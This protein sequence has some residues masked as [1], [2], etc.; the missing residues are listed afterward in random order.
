MSQ[1]PFAPSISD[2]AFFDDTLSLAEFSCDA[3]A[4]RDRPAISTV[5]DF[6]NETKS[7]LPAVSQ[8]LLA[9]SA[10]AA[11]DSARIPLGELNAVMRAIGNGAG[12]QFDRLLAWLDGL[13]AGTASIDRTGAQATDDAVYDVFQAAAQHGLVRLM[14]ALPPPPVLPGTWPG[15]REAL[16]LAAANGQA[17]AVALI[18]QMPGL[19]VALSTA[20][21]GGEGRY[22]YLA[23][24]A[25]G[26]HA[27]VFDAAAVDGDAVLVDS[28]LSQPETDVAQ[29]VFQDAALG[30]QKAEPALNWLLHRARLPQ[31]S[32]PAKNLLARLLSGMSA[33]SDETAELIRKLPAYR[34]MMST[35]AGNRAIVMHAVLRGK[36][37]VFSLLF[38][39]LSAADRVYYAGNAV[40]LALRRGHTALVDY[41][42]AYREPGSDAAIFG[43]RDN[44]DFVLVALAS[45]AEIDGSGAVTSGPSARRLLEWVLHRPEYR[46][47]DVPLPAGDDDDANT[48]TAAL[49]KAARQADTNELRQCLNAAAGFRLAVQ[50]FAQ[51]PRSN[52]SPSAISKYLQHNVRA[53]YYDATVFFYGGSAPDIAVTPEEVHTAV[54]LAT[55]AGWQNIVEY[56][57]TLA[58]VA[59]PQ[60]QPWLERIVP[61]QHMRLAECAGFG[62][63]PWIGTEPAWPVYLA[64][65][66]GHEAVLAFLLSQGASPHGKFIDGHVQTT[67]R[68]PL[69]AAAIQNREAVVR[70]LLAAGANVNEQQAYALIS[71]LR[72]GPDA[73]TTDLLLSHAG[74]NL[75]SGPIVDAIVAAHG[76]D[77]EVGIVVLQKF[78]NRAHQMRVPAADLAQANPAALVTAAAT[79]VT[80]EQLL[81]LLLELKPQPSALQAVHG[82]LAGRG[83]DGA[84]AAL[85][86]LREYQAVV[87]AEEAQC[88]PAQDNP[89]KRL[90]A[91]M[92]LMAVSQAPPSQQQ[93]QADQFGKRVAD[94]L[95]QQDSDLA[96]VLADHDAGG[97]RNVPWFDLVRVAVEQGRQ[98]ALLALAGRWQATLPELRS[99][100]LLGAG[101]AAE[102]ATGRPDLRFV[103]GS[104]HDIRGALVFIA[105]SR[106]LV[107]G[108]GPDTVSAFAHLAGDMLTVAPDQRDQHAERAA[109]ALEL[110]MLQTVTGKAAGQFADII[111]FLVP[112]AYR[113]PVYLPRFRG[114]IAQAMLHVEGWRR[115]QVESLNAAEKLPDH[116]SHAVLD[117]AASE[118]VPQMQNLKDVRNVLQVAVR[119]MPLTATACIRKMVQ[120]AGSDAAENDKALRVALVAAA[121]GGRAGVVRAMLQ[122]MRDAAGSEWTLNSAVR[123]A[124]IAV[125]ACRG[126]APVI[127][128]LAPPPGGKRLDDSP[129]L[130]A[131][132]RASIVNNASVQ[133]LLEARTA[134]PAGALTT[135]DNFETAVVCQDAG[136][137]ALLLQRLGPGAVDQMRL[138]Y[139]SL[140]SDSDELDAIFTEALL[141]ESSPKRRRETAAGI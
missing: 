70:M 41:L 128:E 57:H 66:Y 110:C 93:Q 109:V 3:A 75:T 5:A 132:M 59:P 15:I 48:V 16:E 6:L 78:F 94:L 13:F 120:S 104:P 60:A 119:D 43:L 129:M 131:A 20:A 125:A 61:V 2:L 76:G 74:V 12:G 90:R 73:A 105:I 81:M 68:S 98:R 28:L 123:D 136:A 52:Y 88:S 108:A 85:V 1:P 130:R 87:A 14:R 55:Q 40:V 118:A 103:H 62:Q 30:G 82:V 10:A 38:S 135:V 84:K 4:A 71:M 107:K 34:N 69:L 29:A 122:A 113:P 42:L 33:V 51:S 101:S 27:A 65:T 127:D 22:R 141:A 77:T 19:L 23:L 72:K 32:Q 89:K 21:A 92:A 116:A 24:A 126:H 124:A 25:S 56:L 83:G 31:D 91:R 46:L 79:A 115:D 47:A 35:R 133:L 39:S 63:P 86:R 53:G 49:Q 99:A 58:T 37:P 7:D 9:W 44:N 45:Q 100:F 64:A 139:F 137:V 111:T 17:A 112:A 96:T 54:V 18:L 106:S 134:V 67:F 117:E 102:P 114:I 36:M 50:H 138:K 140:A 80:G 97:V 8:R 26:G 95:A 11:T 121:Y